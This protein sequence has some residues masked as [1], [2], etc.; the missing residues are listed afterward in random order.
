MTGEGLKTIPYI[1]HKLMFA[2]RFCSH[3]VVGCG[4]AALVTSFAGLARRVMSP[5]R[6]GTMEGFGK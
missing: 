4:D 5:D 3:A 1:Y 2:I 6:D